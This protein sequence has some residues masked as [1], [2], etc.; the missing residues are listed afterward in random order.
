MAEKWMGKVK[1]K[2][3]ALRKKAKKAGAITKRGTIEPDWLEKQTHS[4]NRKTRKQ[5]ILAQTYR[6][7]NRGRNKG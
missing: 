1:P 4:K 3:G 5:A 6:R 2:K 7:A